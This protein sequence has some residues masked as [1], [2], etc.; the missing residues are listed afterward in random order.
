MP[1]LAGLDCSSMTPSA[2]MPIAPIEIATR[3]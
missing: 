2:T 3:G 1:R